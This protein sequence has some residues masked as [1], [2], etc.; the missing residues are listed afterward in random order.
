MGRGSVLRGT[1]STWGGVMRS[2]AVITERDCSHP[3][4]T[5]SVLQRTPLNSHFCDSRDKR[6]VAVTFTDKV[7]NFVSDFLD[8]VSIIPYVFGRLEREE[9]SDWRVRGHSEVP[10]IQK[11]LTTHVHHTLFQRICSIPTLANWSLLATLPSGN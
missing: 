3:T 6:A 4:P 7:Y 5:C 11:Y 8:R 9:L 1:L 10:F 2:M